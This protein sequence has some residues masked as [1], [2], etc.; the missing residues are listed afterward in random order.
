VVRD[1]RWDAAPG[2]FLLRG[3]RRAGRFLVEAGQVTLEPNPGAEEEMLGRCFTEEV[4]PAMLR[5]RG[6]LVLHANAALTPDGVVVL[7][8]QSGAGKSTTLAALI[9][10]GCAMLADDVTAVG[11]THDGHSE[12]LP[13]VARVRLTAAAAGGLGYELAP[14]SPEPRRRLKSALATDGQMAD[15][16]GRLLA[17]YV[18]ATHAG[19]QLRLDELSGADKFEALQSCMYGPM[20]VE[21]HPAVFPLVQAVI[22]TARIYRLE[23]PAG[24]WTV[25]EV[26][27]TVL[28]REPRPLPA[29]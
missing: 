21:D 6:L 17:I 14:G 9:E 25:P 19:P 4:L 1:D 13:G 8:G 11:L 26:A 5:H 10:R 23:R 20:M 12:V 7:A 27:D 22:A 3:G 24:G 28:G 29:Q 15:S 2:R 16:P 18:L